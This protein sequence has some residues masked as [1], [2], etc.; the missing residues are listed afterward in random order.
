MLG[1]ML[2]KEKVTGYAIEM[3]TLRGV[4]RRVAGDFRYLGE[5]WDLELEDAMNHC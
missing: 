2:V 5:D 4:L 3:C 1:I